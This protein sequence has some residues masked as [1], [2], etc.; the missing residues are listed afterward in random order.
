MVD[1]DDVVVD[2]VVGHHMYP[3]LEPDHTN[4]RG[5]STWRHKALIGQVVFYRS[6]DL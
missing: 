4:I 2:V 6:L 5:T 1:D 3:Y